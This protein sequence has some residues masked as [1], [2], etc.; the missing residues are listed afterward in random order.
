[1]PTMLDNMI[2]ETGIKHYVLAK[3]IGVAPQ[4]LLDYRYNPKNMRVR[5]V[6]D[7]ARVLREDCRRVFDIIVKDV[8]NERD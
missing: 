4:N 1:M 5:N 6:I 3:K 2:E 8:E 7:L